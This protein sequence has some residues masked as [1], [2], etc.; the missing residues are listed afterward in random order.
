MTWLVIPDEDICIDPI[1]ES[2]QQKGKPSIALIIW[3]VL[4]SLAMQA[5][6]ETR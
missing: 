6:L 2:G 4:R 5:E 1:A 3:P